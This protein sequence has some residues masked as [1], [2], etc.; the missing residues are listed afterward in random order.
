MRARQYVIRRDHEGLPWSVGFLHSESGCYVVVVICD[1]RTQAL[2]ICQ[3]MN[4]Q[5][6][7][8]NVR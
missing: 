7:A 4:G 1:N 3:D 6:G 5:A 8:E 2:A